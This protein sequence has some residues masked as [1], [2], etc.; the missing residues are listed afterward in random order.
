M[1]RDALDEFNRYDRE[2]SGA[3]KRLPK[4]SC[5]GEPIQGEMLYNIGGELYCERCIDDCRKFTDDYIN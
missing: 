3:L 2:Q 5:C 1:C 4:C